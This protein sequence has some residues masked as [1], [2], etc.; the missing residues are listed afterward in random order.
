MNNFKTEIIL[1]GTKHQLAKVKISSVNVG[2]IEI[3]CVDHVRDHGVLME[4]NLSFDSISERN[5][6]LC[7]SN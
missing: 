7:M 6:K 2:G 1:Y 5:V 4:T 3:N